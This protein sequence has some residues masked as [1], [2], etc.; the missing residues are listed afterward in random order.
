MPG[1]MPRRRSPISYAL[2][3]HALAVREPFAVLRVYLVEMP[4]TSVKP[5]PEASLAASSTR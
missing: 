2:A 3:R 5:R 1:E 4:V